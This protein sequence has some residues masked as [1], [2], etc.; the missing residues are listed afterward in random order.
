MEADFRDNQVNLRNQERCHVGYYNYQD[1]RE[2]WQIKKEGPVTRYTLTTSF[3]SNW[4]NNDFFLNNSCGG[5]APEL[6]KGHY[7]VIKTEVEGQEHP[8][9]EVIKGYENPWQYGLRQAINLGEVIQSGVEL[10]GGLFSRLK[11]AW[12]AAT[13]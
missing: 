1:F 5:I 4:T 3:R 11:R 2:N 7:Q 12:Q 9:I 8:D 10:A 13:E 6:P